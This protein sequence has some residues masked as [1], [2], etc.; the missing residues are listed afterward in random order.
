MSVPN[1]LAQCVHRLEAHR[2]PQHF[3]HL[4]IRVSCVYGRPSNSAFSS[5]KRQ[6]PLYRH[7]TKKTHTC[8]R[9]VCGQLSSVSSTGHCTLYCS[10]RSTSKA[11]VKVVHN[12]I[13]TSSLKSETAIYPTPNKSFGFLYNFFKYGWPLT[14][15]KRYP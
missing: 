9:L 14:Y 6:L 1:K 2:L 3:H 15:K 10:F 13:S 8:Q 11:P 4:L 12:A 5:E 7:L